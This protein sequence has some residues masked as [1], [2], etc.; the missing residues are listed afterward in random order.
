MIDSPISVGP[1]KD[2]AIQSP[3]ISIKAITYNKVCIPGVFIDKDEED[4]LTEVQLE[5][6]RKGLEI[7]TK[8][9]KEIFKKRNM[10]WIDV[11]Y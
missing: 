8:D 5:C 3:G 11:Y 6:I 2:Q 10:K 7:A 9:L 1:N 4:Q